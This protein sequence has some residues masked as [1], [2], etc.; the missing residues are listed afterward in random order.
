MGKG[1]RK[2][3][4]GPRSRRPPSATA[5]RLGPFAF[6]LIFLSGCA[7]ANCHVDRALLSDPGQEL[8]NQG[9]AE[10]YRVGCP[11]V[12]LVTGIGQPDPGQL[13]PIA[14][15]G[16][17]DLG[18]L[19]RFRVEGM[20]MASAARQ[21]AAE[22][23]LPPRAVQVQVVE[24]RSQKVYLFGEVTGLQRAV[25]Y[26]GPET[27]LDLLRRTG[28]ITPGAAAGE[29][30]VVRSH[31][32]EGRAPEV[33]HVDLKAVVM[34]HDERTNLRLRPFDQVYVGE[35]LPSSWAKCVP[36]C[37]RPFYEAAWGLGRT[38]G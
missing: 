32:A 6:F 29:V 15:D 4:Q 5:A 14:P 26:Q 9:V 18:P 28:G 3:E 25:P 21:I 33:F 1:N 13:R 12:L 35:S 16:R 20:T 8:W 34:K 2:K 30:H 10:N 31:V 22:A 37:F 23:N 11:D 19:G 24:Y 36:P 27:V 38:G 7:V 17:I